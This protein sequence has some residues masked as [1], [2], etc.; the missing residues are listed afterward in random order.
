MPMQCRQLFREANTS[1]TQ[2]ENTLEKAL[3]LETDGN[4]YALSEDNEFR[5]EYRKVQCRHFLIE[6]FGK[7]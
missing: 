1:T 7:R 6:F 4:C 3:N 2:K 5:I